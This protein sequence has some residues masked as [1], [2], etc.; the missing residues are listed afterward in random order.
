M[1]LLRAIQC[2]KTEVVHY[3]SCYVTGVA[4]VVCM[5]NLEPPRR[6]CQHALNYII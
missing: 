3:H 6:P 2:S 1:T 4:S 5:T